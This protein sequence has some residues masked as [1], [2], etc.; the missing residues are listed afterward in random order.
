MMMLQATIKY[1]DNLATV[2]GRPHRV[3]VQAVTDDTGKRADIDV[4]IC[5][6][7]ALNRP[8]L[9]RPFLHLPEYDPAIDTEAMPYTLEPEKHD[10]CRS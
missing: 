5:P 1:E 8:W 3:V 10:I 2:G 9:R 4:G 7:F 6:T